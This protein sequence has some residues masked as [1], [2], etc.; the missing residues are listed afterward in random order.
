MSDL[1]RVRI[2]EAAGR[3]KVEMVGEVDISNV[4]EIR[5]AIDAKM[6]D[7]AVVAVD[8]SATTFLD[9]SAIALLLELADRLR[10][11]RRELYVII[12][13]DAPIRRLAKIAGLD[14]LVPVVSSSD[15]VN[16]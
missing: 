7:A 10:T 2:H 3:L 9:S 16:P 8:L 1:A 6:S 13:D 4:R 14:A 15:D 5:D 12:P 11:T